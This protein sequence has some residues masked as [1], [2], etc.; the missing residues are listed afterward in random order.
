MREASPLTVRSCPI[1]RMAMVRTD[2]GWHCPQCGSA[3][4]DGRSA[5]A[6]ARPREDAAENTHAAPVAHRA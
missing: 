5:K 4:V 1:C 6:A 3:I 2:V